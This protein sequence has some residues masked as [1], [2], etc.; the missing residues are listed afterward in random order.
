MED[1][2]TSI[3]QSIVYYRIA[4]VASLLCG[5]GSVILGAVTLQDAGDGRV[6]V[7]MGLCQI[8]LGLVMLTLSLA[9]LQIVARLRGH[10]RRQR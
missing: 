9:C 2:K 3:A 4:A 6:F 7:G 1:R 5:V 8:A 10:Q